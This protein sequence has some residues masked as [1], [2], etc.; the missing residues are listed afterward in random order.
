LRFLVAANEIVTFFHPLC[1]HLCQ[2]V[3]EKGAKSIL[4]LQCLQK[5]T[6]FVP[7]DYSHKLIKA[8][9]N[10]DT[11]LLPTTKVSRLREVAEAFTS[12]YIVGKYAVDTGGGMAVGIDWMRPIDC[13][14][15]IIYDVFQNRRAR[16]FIDRVADGTAFGDSIPA[17][18][19]ISAQNIKRSL[20]WQN[21]VFFP[22]WQEDCRRLENEG[23]I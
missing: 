18:C 8:I 22:N 1:F 16:S 20:L 4:A 2:Q 15:K 12:G 14:M 7:K 5:G 21:P 10:I 6:T 13:S 3:I 11:T 9:N 19:G 23:R 17:R